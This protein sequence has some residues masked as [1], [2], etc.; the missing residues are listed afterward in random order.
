LIAG[1]AGEVSFDGGREG[2]SAGVT[3]SA[4]GSELADGVLLGAGVL[5][6]ARAVLNDRKTQTEAMAA[7]KI[8]PLITPVFSVGRQGGRERQ[9][10]KRKLVEARV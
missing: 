6:C 3:N 9:K 7:K 5:V 1:P 10:V 4:R 8:E 2:R